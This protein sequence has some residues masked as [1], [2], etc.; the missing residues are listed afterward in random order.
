M[1]SLKSHAVAPGRPRPHP[2]IMSNGR[3][4]TFIK[5]WR[6]FRGYSQEELADRISMTGGN[7]SLLERGLINYT[8]DTL[9]RLAAALEC[10]VIDLLSRDPKN[11]DTLFN[12]WRQ[13][14][15][16]KQATMI[17]IGKTILKAPDDEKPAS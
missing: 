7:L 10:T 8:Q 17:E 5:E 15:P 6:E 13:A 2:L 1:R 11:S 9:D 3:R 16:T 14:S 12:L 4:P